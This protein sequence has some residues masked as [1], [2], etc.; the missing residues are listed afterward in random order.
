MAAFE[1]LAA[2]E[3][4][5]KVLMANGSAVVAHSERLADG[6]IA[7]RGAQA[8]DL[9]DLGHGYRRRSEQGRELG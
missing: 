6:T 4:R 2:A 5:A 9:G 7:V 1:S 3:A 8:D